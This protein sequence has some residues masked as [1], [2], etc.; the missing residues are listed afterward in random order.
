NGVALDSFGNA[1]V[2]GTTGNP[3]H[4]FAKKINAGGSAFA[5]SAYIGGSSNDTGN[6]IAVDASGN[7]YVTGSTTSSDFPQLGSLETFVA[8]S[9]DAFLTR[10]STTGTIVYSTLLAGNGNGENSGQGVASDSAGNIYV[11][12]MTDAWNFPT[13]PSPANGTACRPGFC[14][15]PRGA[16]LVKFTNDP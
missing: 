10:L 1:Y 5:Y 3:S 4:A 2:A 9:G 15:F 7:A 16:F 11:S 13:T 12:G 6:G 8:G 14:R